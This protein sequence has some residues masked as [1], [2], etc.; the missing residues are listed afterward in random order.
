M[1]T[2]H[3]HDCKREGCRCSDQ[4][5]LFSATVP[6][7]IVHGSVDLYAG[8]IRLTASDLSAQMILTLL[9]RSCASFTD[10]VTLNGN[11]N[12]FP[13]LLDRARHFHVAAQNL[14]KLPGAE[15]MDR[16][17]FW[18][19]TFGEARIKLVQTKPIQTH[20]V[21]PM[22]AEKQSA[23]NDSYGPTFSVCLLAPQTSS[24]EEN[25]RRVAQLVGKAMAAHIDSHLRCVFG[26][27][28]Y[29]PW[30]DTLPSELWCLM[31]QAVVE[32]R[33]DRPDRAT[34]YIGKERWVFGPDGFISGGVSV[35]GGREEALQRAYRER[36]KRL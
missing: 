17:E 8:T 2:I 36:A 27:R 9:D 30:D 1:T 28:L 24:E 34:I 22:C 16:D 7:H 23:P 31:R 10:E 15:D 20:V 33:S 11:P 35:G 18:A 13:I 12:I 5:V 14:A 29:A 21:Q 25:T 26:E 6:E 32:Y 3:Y 4:R 19:R